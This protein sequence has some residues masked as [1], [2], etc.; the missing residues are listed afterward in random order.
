ML[1]AVLFLGGLGALAALG[2]GAA[3][4]R[5]RV[6]VDPRVEALE[7]VLPGVN[8]GACGYAGC[9]A[10]ARALSE[11]KAPANACIPGGADVA[12]AVARILGVDA[13]EAVK[14]IAVVHCKGARGV[15]VDKG[16]YAGVP[17]CN[18]AALV[19]GG[20]K[21]CP[22]GCMGLGSCERSCPFDAIH[23]GPDGLAH[24]DRRKCTGCG[25]CV[26]ACPKKIIDLM[27]ETQWVYVRCTS[28]LKGKAVKSACSKGCIGCRR[29][30]KTCPF[31]AISMDRGLA[32]IDPEKCTSCGLCATVCPTGNIDDLVEVRYEVRIDDR[33]CV[34]CTRC[35]E[36][37]PVEAIA[38]EKKAPHVVD[39]DKCISCYQCLEVCPVGAIA[40]GP[41]RKRGEAA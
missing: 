17:D 2:L 25:N 10:L 27:P 29:C 30:E 4:L 1:E 26:Q 41:A 28:P 22:Y 33:T 7:G 38:G 39:P 24:V 36:A 23:V 18:A 31:D 16:E 21:L 32:R 19:G 20:P 14:R 3:S 13:G 9:G 6:E 12:H 40:K 5:F 8:C 35:V 11:G 37:C 34:G 15:A